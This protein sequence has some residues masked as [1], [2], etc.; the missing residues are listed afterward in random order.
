MFSSPS[1]FYGLTSPNAPLSALRV[2][3]QSSLHTTQSQCDNVRQLLAAL[4]SP[5]Q[6]S[7]LSE[8]YAPPSPA[9]PP[10]IPLEHSRPLSDPIA[11]WRRRSMAASAN[12]TSPLSKRAT[13]NGGTYAALAHGSSNL[14]TP[15]RSEHDK[16]NR[17]SLLNFSFSPDDGRTLPAS[18]PPSPLHQRVLP[19]VQEE[20]DH[21]ESDLP[22]ARDPNVFGV[23]A[24]HLRRKRRSAGLEAIRVPPPSYSSQVGYTPGHSSHHS[25]SSFA[26]P[27]RFSTLR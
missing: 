6:L 17:R 26:S 3:L 11:S 18:A 1:S 2:A 20:D 13:W 22:Y 24:L 16:S 27:T 19:D 8:M 7:Q 21:S 4:T 5:I 25:L 15:R 10:F 23:A 9:R 12:V 14:T